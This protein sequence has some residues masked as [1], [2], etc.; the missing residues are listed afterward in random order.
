MDKHTIC[1]LNDSFP[2]IIDGVA[3]AVVNYAENIEKHHGHAVV[4]TPAVPGA[5]DSGFPFPVVRY[6]SIDTRRLVGYVAG[7][8]FSPETALR[9]REEKVELLHTHCP[10]ASAILARS[11][12]EVVDAPLVL[13]YHTKYDIDIAKAVKS[14]LL[15]E[16]AIRA[17]VQNVNACDEVWVVSR[18]AGENLR[19]LG[20]EGAYTVMENGVDVPR[21]RVSAA[22]VAAATAG[23]DL[24]DGV[25]LLSVTKGIERGTHLRMSQVIA[26]ETGG[27][28]PIA[29]LSGPSHAEEVARAMPTGVVAASNRAETAELVQRVFTNERFRVYTHDDMVGVELAGALKNVAA[30]CCGVSD[31]LGLGDNTKALLITRAMAETS[32]LAER[33]GGRKETLAGLAG[34]GDLIVTCTSMH[35]RNRRAG[36]AIGE[37]RTPQEVVADMGGVVEGYY[38]AVSAKELADSLGV[39]MPICEAM[40]DVLY[41]GAEVRGMVHRLMSRAPK[42]ETDNGWV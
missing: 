21:G 27:E 8:P 33:L 38:A 29:V 30:L 9:V 2:P 23:Y 14:R 40:Y 1:L 28:H 32:R 13:T 6:P 15:Q 31:G 42:R 10:I 36:I 19:S 39:E 18:G 3:N 17:L 11:L 5:D 35:S 4:V 7:Y 34:M 20:Y 41:N 25:P 22:A 26:Q 12:R 16:S 24:P 37:G